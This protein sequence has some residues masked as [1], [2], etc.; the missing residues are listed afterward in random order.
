MSGRWGDTATRPGFHYVP[1]AHYAIPCGA[2][3]SANSCAFRYQVINGEAESLFLVWSRKSFQDTVGNECCPGVSAR[4]RGYG[5]SVRTSADFHFALRV[6]GQIGRR[7]STGGRNSRRK[8]EPVR[9]HLSWRFSRLSWI[10]VRG[11][12]QSGSEE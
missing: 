7:G 4:R 2:S 11:R 8:G 9:Y 5:D 3:Q 12:L 10:Q 1:E 6:H